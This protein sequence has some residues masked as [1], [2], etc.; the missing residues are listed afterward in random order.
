MEIII[1]PETEGQTVIEARKITSMEN[2][3]PYPT[4]TKFLTMQL[5][6]LD[7]V[8]VLVLIL[9]LVYGSMQWPSTRIIRGARK[10]HFYVSY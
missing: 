5:R 7:Q 1:K 6:G 10:L 4:K 2:E 3:Y 8:S 9:V